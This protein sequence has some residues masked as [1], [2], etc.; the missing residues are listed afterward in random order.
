MNF[1][2]RQRWHLLLT[3]QQVLHFLKLSILSEVVS[4]HLIKS[5]FSFIFS[6]RVSKSCLVVPKMLLKVSVDVSVVTVQAR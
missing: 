4:W 6:T 3:L 1:L 5:K 2:E